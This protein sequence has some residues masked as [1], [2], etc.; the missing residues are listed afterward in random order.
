YRYSGGANRPQDA[1]EPAEGMR[2]I[3]AQERTN[4][5]VA[6]SVDDMGEEF[7][8]AAQVVAP[9]EAERVG[10]MMHTALERLVEA[11]EVSPGRAIGSIDVLPVA[12]RAL[13]LEAWDG[14]VAEVPADQCI[15]ELFEAQAARTPRAPALVHAGE[16]LDYEGLERAANR[17]A[18]HLR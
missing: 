15:H 12:E 10:R 17:L 14:T 18:N 6:L 5:P 16:V 1:G 13:V 4:Y 2:G 3:R 11:L 9:A 8:L 7:S